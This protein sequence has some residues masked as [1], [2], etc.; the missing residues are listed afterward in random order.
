MAKIQVSQILSHLK[1]CWPKFKL[2]KKTV[3]QKPVGQKPVGQKP[4]GQ[5]PVGQKPVG[6]KLVGQKPVGQ[7]P[8]GQK[9]VSQILC[10]P[11]VKSA[12]YLVSQ[13]LSQPNI[14]QPNNKSAK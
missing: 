1:N 11:I 9:P 7:K 14:C 2:A 12:K 3:D 10:L 8:I 6:Q 13:I 4:V 5:K